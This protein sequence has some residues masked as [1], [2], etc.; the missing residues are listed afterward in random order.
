[1]KLK[2]FNES[3]RNWSENK[4]RKMYDEKFDLSTLVLDFLEIHHK[5][6]FQDEK[7]YYF[8]DQFWFEEDDE[9]LFNV[10]YNH[11]GYNRKETISHEFQNEEFEN[12]LSY[13]NN[14]EMYKNARKYNI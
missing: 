14:P 6:L 4:I 10:L 7:I 3:I 8:L 11:S 12:L 9:N 5:E 13:M 2:K 1:M